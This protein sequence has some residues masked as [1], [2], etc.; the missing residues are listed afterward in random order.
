[1]TVHTYSAYPGGRSIH[2][3]GFVFALPFLP[4]FL[5][6]PGGHSAIRRSASPSGCGTGML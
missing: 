1:M 5:V 6:A 4:K 2:D 3:R